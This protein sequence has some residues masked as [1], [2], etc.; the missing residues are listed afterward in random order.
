MKLSVNVDSRSCSGEVTTYLENNVVDLQSSDD[1]HT[2]M[3]M[4][5]GVSE[6][7]VN[8]AIELGTTRR[9]F[10]VQEALKFPRMCI[11]CQYTRLAMFTAH[12]RFHMSA[13]QQAHAI[14]LLRRAP[15]F[16]NMRYD[17]CPKQM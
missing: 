14:E 5:E 6:E 17:L 7:I 9:E 2:S 3:E 12:V 8:M 11:F 10:F 4:P 15:A 1:D 13:A 16:S